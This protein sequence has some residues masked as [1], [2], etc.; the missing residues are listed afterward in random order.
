[1]SRYNSEADV[2]RDALLIWEGASNPQ[3][4]SRALTEMIDWYA[5]HCG[6]HPGVKHA[7]GSPRAPLL[8]VQGQLQFLLGMSLG[9]V[10]GADMDKARQECERLKE[11]E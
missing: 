5:T 8:L 3:G 9:D 11:Q 10:N 1:M 7:D 2:A 6:G 4:I